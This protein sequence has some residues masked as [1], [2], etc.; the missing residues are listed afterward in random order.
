MRIA[1][2]M[3]ILVAVA[4]ARAET[5]VRYTVLFQGKP[6]GEQ[7]TR[8]TD[9][10]TVT[11]DYHYRN[12]GRGPDLKEQFA[13]A[14]DGTLRRYTATGKSTYGGPIEDSFLRRNGQAEWKSLSDQGSANGS[15]PSAYVPVDPSPEA[16]MRIVKAVASQPAR[17]LAALPAGALAV[18]KVLDEHLE[19]AG[20]TRD[21]SLYVV[22]GMDFAPNYF[23]VTARSRNV[24]VRLDH[25]GLGASC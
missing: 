16:F 20:K 12:N 9:D 1:P 24:P 25:P 15:E 18:E 22:T 4:P 7:I 11:V 23:W 3:L 5:T 8:T 10:G 2:A 17:Q 19:L 14:N 21:L 13:L 6:S